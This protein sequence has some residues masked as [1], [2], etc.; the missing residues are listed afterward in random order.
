MRCSEVHEVHEV[1]TNRHT[2]RHTDTQTHGH[3]DRSTYLKMDLK[4]DFFDFFQ[5]ICFW[6]AETK[7]QMNLLE[8]LG[9][10]VI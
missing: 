6:K 2:H 10:E 5:P 8:F 9:S 3:T 4:S 1:H 7:L